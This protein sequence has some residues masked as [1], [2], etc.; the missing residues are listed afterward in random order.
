MNRPLRTLTP[1]LLVALLPLAAC[2]SDDG[3]GG[4]GSGGTGDALSGSI[5]VS[6]A[7]SL[8]GT[9]EELAAQFEAEHDGVE[10]ELVFDSSGTLADQAVEGA[11]GDIL[12][13]ADTAS[14]ERAAEAQAEDPEIFATNELVLVTPAENPAGVTG[15]ES[16][17]DDAVTYVICVETAPCGGL[18]AEA[19]EDA[20]IDREPASLERD[21]KATLSRVV[22]DEA[23]A[24]L[25]YR[26]D[27]L[28]SGDDVQTF[29]L[30]EQLTTEY[31]IALLQQSRN[32]GVAQ[33]F[34]DFVLSTAGADVL[35]AAGFGTP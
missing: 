24:G 28:A 8:T 23:D 29:D 9:F 27:A 6:A 16:L 21:V 3:D 34:I 20:G 17:D 14:M 7:A 11:P 4:N 19:L 2:G 26:T 35:T 18:S 30:P 25:V 32:T 13:T 33:A 22:E 10:V 5:T 31:P 12:A 1:A 15:I